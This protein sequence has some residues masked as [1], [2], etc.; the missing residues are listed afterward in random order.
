MGNFFQNLVA[1]EPRSLDQVRDSLDH[2]QAD[3]MDYFSILKEHHEDLK[4]SIDIL[5]RPD[6]DDAEKR[7]HLFRFLR[8]LEMHGKAEQE[9]LYVNL[10]ASVE[11]E[12]RLEGYG[13]KDEHDIAFQ[14]ED[15][16][17]NM[18]YL[19]NWNE[20]IAAKAKVVAGLVLN[21]IKEE[22]SEMFLIAEKSLS[23]SLVRAMTDDYLAKCRRYLD[24]S[25]MMSPEKLG[26]GR[27]LE[28]PTIYF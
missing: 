2:Y 8:L 9:T 4:E 13:G 12:A 28:N 10:K 21:H 23:P 18:G 3:G 6:A 20:E 11:H 26:V 19:M 24:E 22:E 27:A 1:V 17:N 5:T 16:L 7:T 25:K 15:E 14:L